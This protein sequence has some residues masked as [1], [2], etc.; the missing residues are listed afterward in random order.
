M[1]AYDTCCGAIK[2]YR[3]RIFPYLMDR[4][5]KKDIVME[6]RAKVLSH[7]YGNILEIGYGTGLNMSCY[8]ENVKRITAIDTTIMKSDY[9]DLNVDLHKMS[10]AQMQFDD[11]LFILL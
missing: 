4:S 1:F 2:A 6:Y 8:P 5:L 11:E 3:D 10:A 7:A 9:C